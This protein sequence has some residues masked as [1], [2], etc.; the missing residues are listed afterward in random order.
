MVD[1]NLAINDE[2]EQEHKKIEIWTR[3]KSQV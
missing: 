3:N 2:S 1:L